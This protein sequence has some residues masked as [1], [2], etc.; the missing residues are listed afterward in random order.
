[1][2]GSGNLTFRQTLWVLV[3]AG[4]SVI[5]SACLRSTEPQ[6]SLLKLSGS[7]NY[8][9]AETGP[10]RE[11]LTGVLTISR[12][13]GTAFQGRLDLTAV[14]EQTRQ[15][16]LLSGLVSGSQ[17]GTDVIDF[18]ADVE[19]VPRRHVGRIVADTITG[20]WVGASSD[21]ITSSGTFRAER[22]NN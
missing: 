11:T 18:D 6:P 21:G 17:Q 10:A 8:A 19:S 14:N 1:M 15:S 9:G 13:S 2:T 7:W 5:L 12:V 20:T 16:T 22:K 4:S 3:L